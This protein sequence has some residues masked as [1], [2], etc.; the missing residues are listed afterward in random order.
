MP[1]VE[2]GLAYHWHKLEG[3]RGT[4]RQFC[5]PF[6]YIFNVHPLESIGVEIFWWSPLELVIWWSWWIRTVKRPPQRLNYSSVE[7]RN[8]IV[9]NNLLLAMQFQKHYCVFS[10]V[11]PLNKMTIIFN[12][13][14]TFF[15]RLFP[16][17]FAK[18]FPK[19]IFLAKRPKYVLFL[20]YS[21]QFIVNV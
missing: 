21:N 9:V 4:T 15:S 20:V 7:V 18:L 5:N 12:C 14:T 3:V 8:I 2:L 1:H 13:S 17:I 11:L 16:G 6:L 10:C 19:E